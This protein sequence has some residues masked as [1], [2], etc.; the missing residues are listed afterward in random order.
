MGMDVYGK[1]P[2]TEVG[3]YFRNNVWW[4]RA[5]WNYVCGVGGLSDELRELG[6]S[7]SGGGLGAGKSKALGQELLALVENGEVHHYEEEYKKRMD[8]LPEE[9]CDLCHGS[10]FR[11]DAFVKGKCN[12]CQ[13]KGRVRPFDTHY[14]FSAENVKAF[15]EFM[16]ASGGFEIW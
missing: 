13:G 15:A 3:E 16:V 6:H 11:D 9:S 7:N 14:P 12:K 8:S 2:K 5:L 1:N 10:G 4:W